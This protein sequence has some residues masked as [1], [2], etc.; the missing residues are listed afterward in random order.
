MILIHAKFSSDTLFVP[1]FY[2]VFCILGSLIIA[3]IEIILR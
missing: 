2:I 3:E 1:F